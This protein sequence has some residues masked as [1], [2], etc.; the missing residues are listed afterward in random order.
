MKNVAYAIGLVLLVTW[1]L[2]LVG[3]FTAG[4]LIHVCLLVAVLLFVFSFAPS[5]GSFV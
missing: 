3:V 5:H 4:P 2:G 1:N